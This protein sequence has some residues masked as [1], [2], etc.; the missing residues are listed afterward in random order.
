MVSY[1][2]KEYYTEKYLQGR[3]AVISA[4][5]FPQLAQKATQRIKKYSGDN[6]DENATLPDELQM[7]CCEVAEALFRADQEDTKGI[8]SE[9]VGEYAVSYVSPEAK[10]KLLSVSVRSIIYNWLAMTGLLYRGC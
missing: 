3:T 2:T 6:V 7:C 9:K 8:A 5:D 4:A 10:E 1:T